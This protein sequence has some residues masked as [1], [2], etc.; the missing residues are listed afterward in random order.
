MP[1]I[2]ISIDVLF[3]NFVAEYEKYKRF[4]WNWIETEN[5]QFVVQRRKN[6]TIN[7]YGSKLDHASV[8]E[9]PLYPSISYEKNFTFIT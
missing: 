5:Y 9:H 6:K 2:C 1:L 3:L 7:S 4:Y 8:N